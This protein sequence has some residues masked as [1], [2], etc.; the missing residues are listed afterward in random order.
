[1]KIDLIVRGICSLRPGV[2]GLSDNITVRSILGRF[3]EHSRVYYFLN[4]GDEEFY[5][6]S[7]DWMERNLKRRN[8][9]CFPVR[10]KSIRKALK[11]HLDIYLDDNCQSWMLHGD[12]SYERIEPGDKP[13]MSAQETFLEEFAVPSAPASTKVEFVPD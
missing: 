4:G 11:R 2:L 5:C 13:R 3:L 12:G 9:S 1:M 6:A 8:E 10:Q 7:A